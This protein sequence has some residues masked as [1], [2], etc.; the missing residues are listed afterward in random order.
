MLEQMADEAEVFNQRFA[1]LQEAFDKLMAAVVVKVYYEEDDGSQ[2]AHIGFECK[3][4]N[5]IVALTEELHRKGCPVA[6]VQ[7]IVQR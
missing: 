6:E 1:A 2:G 4:C 3:L 7:R 5:R